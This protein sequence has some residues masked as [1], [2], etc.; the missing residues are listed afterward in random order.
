MASSIF[1]TS[2]SG[3]FNPSLWQLPSGKFTREYADLH[4]LQYPNGQGTQTIPNL[5]VTGISALGTLTTGTTSISS[6]LAV[7]GT[8]TAT[9]LITA[10]G[11]LTT[12]SSSVLTSAG[13]TTLTGAT[14]ATGLITANGGVNTTAITLSYSTPPTFTSSQIGY[15]TPDYVFPTT[16]QGPGQVSYGLTLGVGVWQLF[17]YCDVN[18]SQAGGTANHI[19]RNIAGTS[20]QAFAYIGSN[21]LS[22]PTISC[23]LTI[24]SAATVINYVVG[25]YVATTF[26]TTTGTCRY[27]AV[28]IA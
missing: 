17:A 22:Y 4:Y 23:V 1:P 12:G 7:T 9:E 5:N 27:Y 18:T 24:T 21:N 6:T 10:T 26:S 8:T 25:F 16:S 14:T 15:T 20:R 3:I 11:G 19:I 2:Q 28:R 13:T